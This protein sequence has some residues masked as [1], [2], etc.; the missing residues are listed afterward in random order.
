[1]ISSRTHARKNQLQAFYTQTHNWAAV[2]VMATDEFETTINHNFTSGRSRAASRLL[3]V[4][5]K[6][7]PLRV[8]AFKS[9]ISRTSGALVF[10][11]SN[12]GSKMIFFFRYRSLRLS[13]RPRATSRL[14]KKRPKAV[15]TSRATGDQYVVCFST[16]CKPEVCTFETRGKQY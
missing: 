11:S 10:Q 1:M 3:K 14:S 7:F 13:V 9:D 2:V 12:G 15:S 8:R 16:K 5:R 6:R 4:A